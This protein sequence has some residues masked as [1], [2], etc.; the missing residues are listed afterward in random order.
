MQTRNEL[1]V[2]EKVFLKYIHNH[3]NGI[4]DKTHPEYGGLSNN[5]RVGISAPVSTRRIN[6]IFTPEE[7]ALL[8]A[9]FN[10]PTLVNNDSDFWKEY[11]TDKYGM[12]KS[13]F[14][15]FLKKEGA[16]YNK[17]NPV[18]FIYIRILE[19][20]AS[21]GNS[22]DNAKALGLKFAMV[23]ESDQFK[24]EK[25][26]IHES[27]KAF[28]LYNKYE[29]DEK[30]LRY[31][32]GNTKKQKQVSLTSTIDFLQTE[33]WKEMTDNPTYFSLV[34]GDERLKEKMSLHEFLRYKLINK[35]NNLY[36]FEDGRSISLDSTMNDVDGAAAYLNSGIGQ[37]E[38]LALNA[39]LDVLSKPSKTK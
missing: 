29:D 10:D 4:S 2:D 11:L 26:T 7:L 39:K 19:D 33:A 28:K 27:K 38:Y 22:I 8:A 1:F 18:D 17:M 21:V 3:S 30:V 15:I 36:Y 14:P 23:K 35:V 12:S 37:E 6:I 16:M 24:K 31:L 5:A 9:E 32:L 34:L 25:S 13:I 20:S